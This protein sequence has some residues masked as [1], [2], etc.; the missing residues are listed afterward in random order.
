MVRPIESYGYH[1]SP[2]LWDAFLNAD[3]PIA[4]LVGVSEPLPLVRGDGRGRFESSISRRLLAV[5]DISSGLRLYAGEI[6]DRLLPTFENFYPHDSRP[7]QALAVVRRASQGQTPAL[8]LEEACRAAFS[9]A[10]GARGPARAAAFAAAS[11]AFAEPAMA[12]LAVM[13]LAIDLALSTGR[14]AQERAWQ[15]TRFE[16]SFGRLF[17]A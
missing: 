11:A 6:T 8:E 17:E 7:G 12:A 4:A 5:R 3:G 14:I 15:W 1:S 16:E 9:A 10:E 13:S 2:T